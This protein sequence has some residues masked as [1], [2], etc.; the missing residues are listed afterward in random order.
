MLAL[1]FKKT[2]MD[3]WTGVPDDAAIACAR[4]NLAATLPG[5][6]EELGRLR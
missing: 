3:E 2:F 1:E 5:L 6:T 4:T